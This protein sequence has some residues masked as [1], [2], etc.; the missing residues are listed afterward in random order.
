MTIFSQNFKKH[1]W[2]DRLLVIYTQDFNN[3]KV[4]KQLQ[5]LKANKPALI[6]FIHAKYIL[7]KIIKKVASSKPFY[8][9]SIFK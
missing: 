8:K 6:T 2:K 1:Q 7:G 3:E 4:R 9:T 5:L